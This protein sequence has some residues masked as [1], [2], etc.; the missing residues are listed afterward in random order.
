MKHTRVVLAVVWVP[1]VRGCM[2]MGGPGQWGGS[3]RMG[4]PGHGV[5]AGH[6]GDAGSAETA[7]VASG[8]IRP[9]LQHAEASN[10][11]LTIELDLPTPSRGSIVAIDALLRRDDAP[12]E[13]TEGE[14]WLRIRTPGGSVDSLRMQST[15]SSRAGS[16]RAYYGFPAGGQYL[17]TAQGRTGV[18]GD[19]RTVSV[20]ARVDVSGMHGSRPDWLVPAAL[21]SGAGLVALMALMMGSAH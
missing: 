11:G 8:P 13:L 3:G 7:D 15:H 5:G 17:V 16:Y 20:T 6:M 1:S 14:V 19:S 4:G 9:P 18:V 2:M 10:K 12:D 21:L